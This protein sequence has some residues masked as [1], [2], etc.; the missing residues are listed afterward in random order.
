MPGT[1]DRLGY[2]YHHRNERLDSYPTFNGL[3][4]SS[5]WYRCIIIRG[6]GWQKDTLPS[7]LQYTGVRTGGWRA[8][9]EDCVEGRRR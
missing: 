3:A 9:Y 1:E 4:R 7:P 6:E 2:A 8:S 5:D